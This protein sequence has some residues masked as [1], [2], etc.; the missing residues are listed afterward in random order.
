MRER[1]RAKKSEREDHK[2]ESAV[3][4]LHFMAAELIVHEVTDPSQSENS[5]SD[6]AGQV[7]SKGP[8]SYM[9][10]AHISLLSLRRTRAVAEVQTQNQTTGLNP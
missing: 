6:T 8:S 7:G 5:G 1:E 3:L 4:Y 10:T 2:R 9:S